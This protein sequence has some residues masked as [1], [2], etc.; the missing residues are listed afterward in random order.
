M[1][2]LMLWRQALASALLFSV[3][4][5][6]M[7][8][9]HAQ[10]DQTQ[11]SRDAVPGDDGLIVVSQH[12]PGG[13]LLTREQV[14]N[15]FMGASLSH[16]LTPIALPPGNR[17]RSL[18]NAKVIGLSESRIQAY[19]AQL[20]FTG[21]GKAPKEVDDESALLEYL[22]QHPHSVGYLPAAT[23]LPESMQIIFSL[24]AASY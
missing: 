17:T 12:T 19:W 15:L 7:A 1:G 11:Q 16:N 20:K 21:R 10:R 9:G 13:L 18:F 24:D 3:S 23:P 14:R 2:V 6:L 8:A 5:H 22:K 4:L